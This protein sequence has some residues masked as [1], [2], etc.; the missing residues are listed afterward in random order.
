[1]MPKLMRQVF[2]TSF[3]RA[4]PI[5]TQQAATSLMK[6]A[7][8]EYRHILDSIPE[9]DKDDRFLMNILSAAML[10][11]VLKQLGNKPGLEQVTAYYHKA[12][13][14]NAVMKLFLRKSDNYNEKAQ[15]KLAKQ[16]L[17]SQKCANPYS[18][19]FRYEA[20]ADINSYTVTFLSCG[21][22]YLFEMQGLREYIPAMCT[23]DYDMAAGSGTIF[24]RQ[25]TLASGGP[26]CDCH[27]QKKK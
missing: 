2:V 15:S 11:A 19:K 14:E 26:C 3:R 22:C 1:M 10:V 8:T 27:Y 25:Y 21:I 18:W 23:Y 13:N 16:A 17:A 5:I 12:M 6:N 4:L 7:R 20:G 24:T 9:F